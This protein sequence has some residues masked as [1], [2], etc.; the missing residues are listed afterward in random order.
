MP[1]RRSPLEGWSL[2]RP[3]LRMRELPHLAQVTLRADVAPE[4]PALR[5]GPDEWLVVGAP[6]EAAA[7]VARL[8]LA[9]AGRH[10]QVV[11][12]GASRTVIE[13]AGP[14]GTEILEMGCGLDLHPGAF[15]PGRCASTV[16]ARTGVILDLVDSAPTWRIFVRSSYARY[17]RHWLSAATGG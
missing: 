11:D 10:A 2:E 7:I 16:L 9:T 13:L 6:G 4:G 8:E 17:L 15:P 5:L 1:E 12:T 14:R 3:G